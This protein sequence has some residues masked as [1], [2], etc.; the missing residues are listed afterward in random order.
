MAT[1]GIARTRYFDRQFLR[2]GDFES[3]Q[4]YH[5]AMRRRHN[6]S[7]HTWGIVSGLT[8][9]E[10][11]G[12]LFLQPGFAVDG[13]GR[14]LVLSQRTQLAVQEFDRQRT[15]VLD[16]WIR[17]G[18]QDSDVAP[19]GYAGCGSAGEAYRSPERPVVR[20]E[21]PDLSY[22]NRRQPKLVPPGD[23]GFGATRIP[24]DEPNA[25][26]PVFLGQVTRGGTVDARTYTI[27]PADR[28]YAGLV[29]ESVAAPSGETRLQIGRGAD[30]ND[31]A[32]FAVFV[33]AASAQQ[34]GASLQIDDQNQI[35]LRGDTAVAGDV[36]I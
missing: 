17:Y 11:E 33:P 25:L 35:T 22:P 32:G 20:F 36:V 19:K 8:I 18:R 3:E 2:P 6:V 24:P 13:Y 26:W 27:N 28:P 31:P 21:K 7:E 14:E 1:T 34:G 15:E 4:A 12:A 9:Q 23:Y 16:V 5:L 10:D 29:G 30:P